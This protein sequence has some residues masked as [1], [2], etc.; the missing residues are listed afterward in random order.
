MPGGRAGTAC[1]VA[2]PA[3]VA[4]AWLLATPDG[5]DPAAAVR[6]LSDLLG[7]TVLGL[8]VLSW[9]QRDDR[10]PAVP[11]ARLWRPLSV[12]AA[13]WAATELILL[14]AA[15]SE[16]AVGALTPAAFGRFIGG[17]SVGQVGAATV[18]CAAAVAV[19][20]AL[21][22]RSDSTRSVTPVAAVAA[23]A[24]LAR[25][26][27]GH[28]SAQVLGS[29]LVAAH[30]LAAALWFGPLVAMAWLLRGR[31]PW[32]TLLPRYST[33]AWKCV[34]V[35]AVT[36]IV[37]GAVALGGP[38]ALVDTGYGRI[39]LAKAVALA[40]LAALGW[41]WRRTWVPAAATH[42]ATERES[43]RRSTIEVVAL[44]VVFGLAAGLATTG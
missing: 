8:C 42:R 16:V 28:M 35:L 12:T 37:D 19:A 41:W 18:L 32:A 43:L 26:V 13:A 5:P 31:S 34:A 33:L 9:L 14:V 40:G 17:I 1:L 39:L 38:G 4:L 10:R 29:A 21:G 25:P 27:T 36:G 30:V 44:A 11:H 22:H 23:V 7:S 20:A 3:G 15:A 2:A 6:A 24:L